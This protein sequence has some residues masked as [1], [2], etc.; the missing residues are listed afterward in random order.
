MG[1]GDREAD[2]CQMARGIGDVDTAARLMGRWSGQYTKSA[3]FLPL[4]GLSISPTGL[5]LWT[6]SSSSS[7]GG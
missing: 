7:C 4:Q 3:S 6:R 5:Q 2:N 1:K